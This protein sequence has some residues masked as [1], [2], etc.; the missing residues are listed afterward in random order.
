[1]S[2]WRNFL[3]EGHTDAE[4]ETFKRDWRAAHPATVKFWRLINQATVLAVENPGETVICNYI[5]LKC[6][7]AFLYIKLPS[8][9]SICYPRPSVI[10]GIYG[11][12]CVSFFDNANGQFKPARNGLGGFGGLFTENIVQGIAR[13]ILAAALLRLERA[14]YP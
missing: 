8:G 6:D 14:G 9:R 1:M 12:P 10:E 2:A 7:G 11:D 5:K 3:P 4:V 13:D